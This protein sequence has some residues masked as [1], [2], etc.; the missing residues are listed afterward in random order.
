MPFIS[1][2]RCLLCEISSPSRQEGPAAFLAPR[3][4]SA[5][6][7][8]LAPRPPL[9]DFRLKI[10]VIWHARTSASRCA[11]CVRKATARL[12]AFGTVLQP[13]L[14][15]IQCVL[16]LKRFSCRSSETHT[17]VRNEIMKMHTKRQI[18]T[19]ECEYLLPSSSSRSGLPGLSCGNTLPR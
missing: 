1:A 3:D 17:A 12:G 10:L 15:Q 9:H 11:Q 6:Q 2:A 16:V 18:D 5:T 19:F 4:R 14:A 8:V 7:Q 13:S